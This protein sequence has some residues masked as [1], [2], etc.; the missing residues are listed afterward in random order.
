MFLSGGEFLNNYFIFFFCFSDTPDG[1]PVIGG[2]KTEYHEGD[3]IALNCTSYRARPPPSILW[4][5][6]HLGYSSTHNQRPK[7][8]HHSS[9]NIHTHHHHNKKHGNDKHHKKKLESWNPGENIKSWSENSEENQISQSTKSPAHRFFGTPPTSEEA[10][11]DLPS[12]SKPLI[13][14]F[15]NTLL[16]EPFIR[17]KRS[18]VLSSKNSLTNSL[19][20]GEKK[21]FKNSTSAIKPQ[22]E[23]NGNLT[24]YFDTLNSSSSVPEIPSL[25]FDN[26]VTFPEYSNMN[27]IP[28]ISHDA[29]GTSQTGNK[30]HR[31]IFKQVR[32]IQ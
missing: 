19:S 8:H 7:H 4:T 26:S 13:D 10:A 27:I 32:H 17:F 6:H 23:S 16:V 2:L 20:V 30:V 24:G 5:Y 9:S 22:I 31:W 3:I 14:F 25:D 29:N 12:S 18:I 11:V 28:K 15:N 1:P 21:S